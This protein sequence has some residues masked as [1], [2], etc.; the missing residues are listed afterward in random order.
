MTKEE[1]IEEIRQRA[2]KNFSRGYNCSECVFEAVI[3]LVDTELPQEVKKVATGFGG[4]VGLYGDSCGAIVGA[5]MAVSA[6]HGRSSLPEGE[7]KEAAKKATEQL[8]GKPGLYRLFNQV[9][10]R[11]KEKYGY[12]LCRDLTSEWHD[13]WLCR[14]HALHCREIIT[15]A[16][17]IAAELILSDKDEIASRPFGANVENV[18]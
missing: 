4:G 12:T 15:D 10:N 6:V 1:K 14:E 7:G 5:V 16:A 11:V 3:S 9:P 8:Y 17:E 13:N 18:K 2:R